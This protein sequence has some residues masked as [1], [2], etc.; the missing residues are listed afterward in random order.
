MTEFRNYPKIL[1]IKLQIPEQSAQNHRSALRGGVGTKPDTHPSTFHLQ[2]II[3]LQ[4]SLTLSKSTSSFF[5]KPTPPTP[6]F[7]QNWYN[8]LFSMKKKACCWKTRFWASFWKT[9]FWI[10]KRTKKWETLHLINK[11]LEFGFE[12]ISKIE[13]SFLSLKSFF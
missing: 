11:A 9:F 3:Y 2:F 8:S 6:R 13:L 1:K 7:P 10:V 4:T 12:Q 5:N